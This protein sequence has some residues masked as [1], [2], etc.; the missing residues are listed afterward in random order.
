VTGV[1]SRHSPDALFCWIIPGVS[2]VQLSVIAAGDD[3]LWK[4]HSFD[5]DHLD[6]LER[7]RSTHVDCVEQT[8]DDV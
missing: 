5:G 4:A 8:M 6:L 2:D 7:V 1:D 3:V